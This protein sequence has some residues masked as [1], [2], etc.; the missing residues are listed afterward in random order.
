MRVFV[1]GATGFIGSAIV[2]DLLANGHEVTG[3]ARSGKS[4][5]ALAEAGA[6]SVQGTIEDLDVLR[7]AAADADGVIHAAY[8][9]DFSPTANPATF[10]EID[11]NAIGAIGDGLAGTGRPFVVAAGVPAAEDGVTVTEDVKAPDQPAYPRFSEQAALQLVDRGVRVSVVRMPPSVHGEGD[12]NFV[13][14]LTGVAR[15]KGVSAYVG[16]GT[17][18]WSAVHRNDAARA[19]RAALEQAP[20]GTLLNAVGDEGVPFRDVAAAIGRNLNVPVTSV[21]PEEAADHFGMPYAIFAQFHAPAS[22][23]RT[24]ERFAWEPTEPGLIEDIDLGH[25]FTA[26][27]AHRRDQLG[28]V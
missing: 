16:D 26:T 6:G 3:L 18:V 5:A 14:A 10:A 4:A 17:N 20:A 9:H 2:R 12:P 28:L 13:L 25:Y 8:I 21:S 23:K 27:A 19:F 24:R 7:A 1:T 15:A 11:R 22:G